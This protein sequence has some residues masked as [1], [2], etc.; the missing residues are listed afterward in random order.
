MGLGIVCLILGGF[1]FLLTRCYRKVKQ[2]DKRRLYMEEDGEFTRTISAGGAVLLC[3]ALLLFLMPEV[4]SERLAGTVVGF[5]AV[6][7]IGQVIEVV[8][9]GKMKCRIN[10]WN[11]EKREE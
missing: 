7:F 6:Y 2:D 9:I 11:K 8:M 5:V 3:V 4:F 1:G 10:R